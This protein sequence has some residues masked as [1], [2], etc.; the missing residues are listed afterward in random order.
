MSRETRIIFLKKYLPI[1]KITA[2]QYFKFPTKQKSQLLQA[3]FD[4]DKAKFDKE[5]FNESE[6][7]WRWE[8]RNDK[9]SACLLRDIKSSSEAYA[10]ANP[11]MQQILK[12]KALRKLHQ[13]IQKMEQQR[14]RSNAQFVAQV[15]RLNTNSTAFEI[16]AYRKMFDDQDGIR[17]A[18]IGKAQDEFIV[19][20]GKLRQQLR[21]M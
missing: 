20:D 12:V 17:A 2:E 18:L 15:I 10:R 7:E 8:M 11:V 6:A 5:P 21:K 9:D 3:F 4:L 16:D 19:K 14:Q 1:A 13:W